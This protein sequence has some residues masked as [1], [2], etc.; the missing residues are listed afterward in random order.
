MNF[1]ITELQKAQMRM[2]DILKV[3]DKICKANDIKYWLDGGTLLGAVR[4]KG[5]IPWDDDIDI[6]MTREDYQK[7]S[8]IA[9]KELPSNLFLQTEYTDPGYF[10]IIASMKV[11]DKNSKILEHF[12]T[13]DE[14]YHLGL[15]VDIFAYDNLPKNKILRFI[16]KDF[17][18]N[19]LKIKHAKLKNRG[20]A[21]YRLLSKIISAE[22][23][24]N[25]QN[26]LISNSNNTESS[27]F[28]FGYD[29]ALKRVY[30]KDNF[31][32]L[33]ELE[34]EGFHFCAPKEYDY[35]LTHTY[36]NYMKLP[37]I[38]KQKPKHIKHLEIF[39]DNT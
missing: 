7:F 27:Y 37:P 16:K 9:P 6:A 23:L 32:P 18:R 22:T 12:E 10:N 25:I 34:F 24:D 30:K 35:Y 5:F 15:F 20:K 17:A 39:G 19:I 3:I 11:R 1:D 21:K 28:G 4:H 38:E 13:G 14:S 36:G 33:I 31:F 8:I 2:L 29:C 26:N